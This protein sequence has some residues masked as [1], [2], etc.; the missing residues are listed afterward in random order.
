MVRALGDGGAALM[1]E[2]ALRQPTLQAAAVTV[3]RAW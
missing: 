3:L 1:T 2:T